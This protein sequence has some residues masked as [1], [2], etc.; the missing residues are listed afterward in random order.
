MTTAATTGQ[1][2]DSIALLT[3]FPAALDALVRDLPDFWIRS[4]EGG[5]TWTVYDI[6]GHLAWAERTNWI[7]RIETLLE[8]G[9]RRAFDDFD[10]LGQ[11]RESQGKSIGQLLDEFAQLRAKNLIELR[12]LDL[13]DEQL[14]KCGLHPSLGRVTLAQLL[15]TWAMHDMTHLHQISRVIAYQHRDAVGPWK[16]FLSVMRCGLPQQGG[17]A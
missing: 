3:R 5:S 2:Q 13:A 17:C 7:Q 15:A 16:E 12:N 10:R 1:L 9:E 6:V 14:A 11:V 4:N 8:F